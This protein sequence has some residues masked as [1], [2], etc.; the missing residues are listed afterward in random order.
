MRRSSLGLLALA[1]TLSAFGGGLFVGKA[2]WGQRA[3]ETAIVTPIT[4]KST[5]EVLAA[6]TQLRAFPLTGGGQI[7]L[8]PG[9]TVEVERTGSSVTVALLQ[10]MA[11]I[12]SASQ[13]LALVAGE[14][15]INTQAGS[16][17]V[18]TRNAD[19]LDV[20]VTDGSVNVSSPAG[21]RQ[22]GRQERAVAVPLHAAISATT[23]DA[24]PPRGW[25]ARPRPSAL[26]ARQLVAKASNGPEWFN[27]YQSAEYEPARTLLRKQGVGLAIE[28]AGSAGE[29]NAIADLVSGTGEEIIAWERLLRTFPSDQHAYVAATRLATIYDGRGETARAKA[30][31]DM[32]Q[33]LAQN[34]TT[35]SD[36]LLCDAIRREPD[37]TKAAVR[38]KEY[39]ATN[40]DG[41]CREELE[42]LVQG[43]APAPAPSANPT[44]AP[45]A[46]PT[47]APLAPQ[48][49]QP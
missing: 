36:S 48:P 7:T 33:T 6:G 12:E 20:S 40:P 22:L 28:T 42:R 5:V 27:H 35:G 24:K 13:T 3:P 43:N 29:L 4:E 45:S 47:A 8:S 10:G 44:A 18:V 1:A 34:A 30:Y 41:E 32:V 16:T 15:R 19:D 49:P 38:A 31:H 37:K 14:A 26:G 46:N 39:L 23:I 25:A 2:T 21:S 9:A 17:F 11:S